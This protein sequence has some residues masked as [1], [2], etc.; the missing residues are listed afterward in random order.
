MTDTS[1][2]A[3]HPAE[4]VVDRVARKVAHHSAEA[5]KIHAER[6]SARKREQAA[7]YVAMIK[8]VVGPAV[9]DMIGP[10]VANMPDDHPMKKMA[11]SLASPESVFLA[12]LLEIVGFAAGVLALIPALGHIFIQ[13]D[14]NYMWSQYPNIP[15]PPAVIADMI[16]RDILTTDGG[17]LDPYAEAAK[18]GV[19]KER[20]D[21]M[22]LDTGEPYGVMEALA[23]LRRGDID[24][25]EFIKVLYYSRVRNDFLGDVLKLQQNY[26]SPADAVEIALK[27][28]Q[29]EATAKEYFMKAGGYESNWTDLLAAAGNPSGVVNAVNQY[30]HGV[31]DY[32]TVKSVILHSRINPIFE[33]L[34]LNEHYKW[35]TATQIHQALKAGS[36]TPEVATGWLIE[37]GYDQVQAAAFAGSATT[38]PVEGSKH[39]NVSM[40]EELYAQQMLN[41]PSA[42]SA[43]EQL[44][45]SAT[46]AAY[47]LAVQDAKVQVSASKLAVARIRSLF[48]AGHITSAQ[49]NTELNSLKVPNE[50]RATYLNIWGI[51]AGSDAKRLSES[52]VGAAMRKG[53]ITESTAI[54]KWMAMGFSQEDADTL[55]ALYAGPASVA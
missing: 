35:L 54:V 42:L 31:I 18:S 48:L 24:E 21:L 25:A 46:D 13:P 52:Q 9:S 26:M 36:I 17:G 10:V 32:A 29:S 37:D 28:I 3:E 4:K 41:Q 45:Y 53:I 50:A 30:Y 2:E 38:T 7:A 33:P 16:E 43:L 8:E 34:A 5:S 19:D 14:I 15:L 11:E 44:G 20:L 49:A 23:L 39:L 55:V 12:G 27:G 6:E 51:E 47:I 22:T 1:P 40:I